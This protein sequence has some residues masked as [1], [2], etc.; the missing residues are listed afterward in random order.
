MNTENKIPS[1]S[2][3]EIKAANK[4]KDK[5]V[6]IQVLEGS[7]VIPPNELKES[8]DAVRAAISFIA[9]NI[10]GE[11]KKSNEYHTKIL[12]KLNDLHNKLRYGK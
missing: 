9:G 10:H 2:E 11:D 3:E 7:L 12:L 1:F 6:T 4:M 5:W 8:Y